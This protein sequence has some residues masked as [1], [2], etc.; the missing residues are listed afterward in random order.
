MQLWRNKEERLFVL[1]RASAV[2]Y[3][4]VLLA[5]IMCGCCSISVSH[6]I[7]GG[8]SG[9]PIGG[10]YSLEDVDAMLADS[11]RKNA[12]ASITFVDTEDF[13][14]VPLKIR[15]FQDGEERNS[16]SIGQFL[17]GLLTLAFLPFYNDTYQDYRVKIE[18]PALDTDVGFTQIRRD[19]FSILSPLSLLP[20]AFPLEGYTGEIHTER[21]NFVREEGKQTAIAEGTA[22]AVAKVVISTLT[23]T[24]YEVCLRKIEE[25]L[26]RKRNAEEARRQELLLRNAESGWPNEALLR[27]FALVEASVIWE[28][29]IELRA[30]ASIRKERLW[31]LKSTLAGFGKDDEY[32]T[33]LIKS[34]DEYDVVRAAL[35][36]IFRRLETAYILNSKSSASVGSAEMQQ[37]TVKAI[38]ACSRIAIDQKKRI[39]KHD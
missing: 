33:D 19:S 17:P 16:M 23:K 5:F 27:D 1:A 4:A 38:E 15:Y 26:R 2:H 34:Q 32:D 35:V 9:G 39:F 22:N 25:N 13:H 21:G 3:G 6:K 37:K 28:V 7:D 10:R 20:C 11:L 30:E 36:Q 12:P 29:I 18:S 14:A 8:V 31:Q 24:R